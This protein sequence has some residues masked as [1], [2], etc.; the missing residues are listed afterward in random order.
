MRLAEYE[1][2]T[3]ASDHLKEEKI[4]KIVKLKEGEG[5]GREGREEKRETQR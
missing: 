4:E 3:K 2:G 1:K 5:K